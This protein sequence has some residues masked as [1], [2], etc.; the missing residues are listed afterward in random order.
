MIRPLNCMHLK[1]NVNIYIICTI[2][3]GTLFYKTHSS[4]LYSIPSSRIYYLLMWIPDSIHTL[5]YYHTGHP[6][7]WMHV[8]FTSK[9][10][11]P[12][13]TISSSM[14][15]FDVSSMKIRGVFKQHTTL[16]TSC[17]MWSLFYGALIIVFLSGLLC[18]HRQ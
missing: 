5:C 4:I 17:C 3:I 10:T 1:Y 16:R 7:W 15:H 11:T 9:I 12:T 8:K 13:T 2:L 14:T 18:I 6:V